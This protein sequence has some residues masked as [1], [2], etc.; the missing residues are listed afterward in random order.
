MTQLPVA[1]TSVGPMVSLGPG[2]V[3]DFGDVD[4]DDAAGRAIDLVLTN[5]GGAPLIVTG[6][7]AL[8]GGFTKVDPAGTTAAANGGIMTIPITFRPAMERA[9][10]TTFTITT[11]GL[12]EGG[13]QGP[14]ALT[15]TVRGRGGDQHLQVTGV[16]F[17]DTYRD[18]TDAQ[19]PTVTCGATHDHRR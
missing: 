2:M 16:I 18:P 4:V 8:A 7:G 11:T 1:F 6:I 14:A 5:H 19:V 10:K 9:E 15:I 17:P 12:Y 13:V 3:V